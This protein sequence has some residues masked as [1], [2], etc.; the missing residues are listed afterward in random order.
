MPTRDEK[1]IAIWLLICC[2]TIFGMVVLGGVTRLTGSGLSMVQWAPIMGVLPP[3]GEVEWQET[4][5]LYKQFPEYQKKNFHMTVD[6]FK[7]IFWFEY[8]HR[9]LGRL[10]G[11]MF[12]IPMVYFIAMKK[13]SKSLLPKLIAMFVLGG[14]QGLMGW[15]MVKSG[16]VNDPHVSQYRLTAHLGLAFL[17]YAYLF[18]VAMSL[19]FPRQNQTTS[20]TSGNIWL[21]SWLLLAMVFTTAMSGGFVAGL[22][23]GFAYNTFPLMGGQWIPEGI[24]A[25]EPAWKN[26]FE[27]VATVQF[28]HR[29]LAISLF[30]IIPIFWYL[31]K[32][33]TSGGR[34]RTGLHLLL[35]MLI[36][37]V[38]LG[39]STLLMH[40]PVALAAAHQGGALLLF[41]I[42][43]FV[44]HQV[45]QHSSLDPKT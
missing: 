4:F 29:V 42:M 45:H 1:S 12:F 13:V 38:I 31:A 33:R 32:G 14:L 44:T 27:N 17:V 37:Q 9:I 26:V 18:W 28:Q 8:A 19:L 7:S 35:A 30:F 16:L 39:I 43:L 5:E 10:I 6:D 22:K 3:L 23:A 25:L 2:A 41:T 24:M 34:L 40:V 15:Y 11:L 20:A 36:I 21:F